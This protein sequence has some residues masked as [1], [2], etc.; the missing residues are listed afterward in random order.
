MPEPHT[1]K[2]RQIDLLQYC[3]CG[4][5]WICVTSSDPNLQ[6]TAYIGSGD[7]YTPE[8]HFSDF[9]Y[10]GLL[11]S[12]SKALATPC[13]QSQ[14]SVNNRIKDP[15]RWLNSSQCL[16]PLRSGSGSV[17][18]CYGSVSKSFLFFSSIIRCTVSVQ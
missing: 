17:N 7:R 4:R 10:C 15:Y 2:V 13:V 3:R 11:G 8:K 9:S 18:I 12:A 5:T 14:N 1:Q 6:L 16:N